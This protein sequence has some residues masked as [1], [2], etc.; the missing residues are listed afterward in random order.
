MPGSNFWG[1]TWRFDVVETSGFEGFGD[2]VTLEFVGVESIPPDANVYLVDRDLQRLVDVRKEDIYSFLM[3]RSDV[4]DETS[5]RFLLLVG[6]DR[7]LGSHE[8]EL[9]E[10]PRNAA[11]HSS[12]PNPFN[13]STIVRYELAI[14]GRVNLSI[15]D[16]AG[17]LVR[18]LRE[19]HLGPGRYEAAWSGENDRGGRV[20]TGIYFCRLETGTG[21]T[22]TRKILM[23]R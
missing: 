20:G 23:I 22:E 3:G 7:F 5:A 13:G 21:F 14:A 10:T 17:S 9:P 12:Y 16:A 19:A 8:S 6:S 18:V 2:A 11:L 15:Y 1:Y 4:A